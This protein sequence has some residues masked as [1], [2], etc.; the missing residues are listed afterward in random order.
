MA[1]KVGVLPSSSSDTHVPREGG[2]KRHRPGGLTSVAVALE[3]E[4]TDQE[5]RLSESIAPGENSDLLD[6]EPGD[7]G[8]QLRRKCGDTLEIGLH[9]YGVI[10]QKVS[11]VEPFIDDDVGQ[12]QGQGGVGSRPRLQVKVGPVGRVC[13]S[14]I[15]HRHRGSPFLSLKDQAPLVDIGL[16][17]IVAPQENE[18]GCPCENRMVVEIGAVG[19]S[20]GFEPGRPAQVTVCPGHASER[21]PERLGQSREGPVTPRPL[22]VEDPQGA[23]LFSNRPESGN[24]LVQ[25][26]VPGGRFQLPVPVPSK[27]GGETVRMVSPFH[28]GEALE[29]DFTCRCWI[30][31]VPLDP[32]EPSVLHRRQHPASAVAIAGTN[33]PDHPAVHGR[34]ALLLV[35]DPGDSQP[36]GLPGKGT[37]RCRG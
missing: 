31:G 3:P 32:H 23:R 18:P 13:G 24:D 1:R 7:P 17:W 36:N 10:S 35:F 12:S 25:N 5:S 34:Y 30:L 4:T 28:V 15:H 37:P 27:R 2:E 26:V 11:V 8:C 9:T 21:A 19:E 22:V 6:F 14:G 29:A 33:G 16:R 20:S